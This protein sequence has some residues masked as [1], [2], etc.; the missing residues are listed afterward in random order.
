MDIANLSDEDIRAELEARGIKLHHKT[1][2]DKLKETLIAVL[3]GTYVAP[4]PDTDAKPAKPT[5]KESDD[6]KRL[7]REEHLAKM[8]KQQRAM[9]MSRI[10]VNPNDPLMSSYPGMIFT[11]GS[12]S[13]NNG[14]MIKKFVPFNNDAGWHVPQII[15]DQIE[16]AQ[17]QKF[18]PVTA[19]NGE[20]SLQAYLTKKF[21]VQYL[22]ALTKKEMAALAAAQ[23]AKGDV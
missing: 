22:P 17:M 7:T 11:V 21:N 2:S 20:K 3:D 23:Q 15:I 13:V 18:R 1:G 4:A 14:R 10:V 8:T 16:S 12:S 6:V 9:H 19:P 5:N